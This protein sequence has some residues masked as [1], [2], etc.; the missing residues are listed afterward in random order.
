VRLRFSVWTADEGPW[1]AA[2]FECESSEMDGG[3]HYE[4]RA[5]GRSHRWLALLTAPVFPFGLTYI[6]E[7][8]CK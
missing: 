2:D 1:M 4:K 5:G 3:T 8:G 7:A 6:A